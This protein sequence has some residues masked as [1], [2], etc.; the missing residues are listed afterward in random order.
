MTFNK[1]VRVIAFLEQ[2]VSYTK[3]DPNNSTMVFIRN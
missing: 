3:D 1:Q 2:G